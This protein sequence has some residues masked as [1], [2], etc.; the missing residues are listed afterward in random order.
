MSGSRQPEQSIRPQDLR[1]GDVLLSRGSARLGS[2]VSDWIAL[3]DGGDYSHASFWDGA[4]VIE[5]TG[6]EGK[7]RV[8][9][10]DHLQHEHEYVHVYRFSRHGATLGENAW[11]VEPVVAVA[12]SYIGGGYAYDE[13][14]L[15]GVLVGLG[16]LVGFPQMQGLMRSAGPK[17]RSAL[18]RLRAS[19]LRPMTCSQLVAAVFFEADPTPTHRY[20]LEVPFR[21]GRLALDGSALEAD[22]QFDMKEWQEYEQLRD[23]YRALIGSGCEP[24]THAARAFGVEPEVV[25][26][27]DPRLPPCCVTPS[28]LERSPTLVNLG[29][30]A[31]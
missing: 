11:P 29:A 31:G 16:R 22:P 4:R 21:V 15:F 6:C 18:P 13:L 8:D 23:G 17:L 5:A 27:G 24:Q 25:R 3:L 20:T 12:Q 7:I 28:D 30:L 2:R 14:Y 10:L 9:S 26:I 1:A 19:E